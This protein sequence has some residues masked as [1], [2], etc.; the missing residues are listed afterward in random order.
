VAFLAPVA[1]FL[2]APVPPQRLKLLLLS[3]S[4]FCMAV[5]GLDLGL[6]PLMSRRL[7]YTPLNVYAHKLPQLPIVGRWDPDLHLVDRL[8]GDLAAVL[9]KAAF[10]EYREVA[11]LTDRAGFRNQAIPERADVI[12]LGDSFAA[13]W[14]TT[15]DKI[16]ARLLETRYGRRVY[17]LAY[18]GGPYDQF[19]NLCIESPRMRLTPDAKVVWTFYTGND[20]DDA[21]GETWDVEK[22][23]WRGKLGQWQV[24]YRTYRNRSPLNRLMEA[25]RWRLS[26]KHL[27]VIV[28][29][30]SDGR[31]V[32]FQGGHEAWARRSRDE[33]EQHPNFARLERTLAAMRRRIENPRLALTI[34]ILPTKGQVYSWLL[35]QDV[36]SVP[37]EPSSGFAQAVLGACERTG[38][39]CLDTTP[40][41]TERAGQVFA[42]TGELLWWR[43]DTHLGEQGHEALAEF[44][45]DR[46][47]EPRSP[48]AVA[49]RE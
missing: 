14:G 27:D 40:Y 45:A 6:R 10:R 49:L 18:P 3:L 39:R 19:V 34:L 37:S 35:G 32:L 4:V 11:F 48:S 9:G 20:L 30:L 16:F 42:S 23:P 5:S 36:R 33:V 44:I 47:L 13:G 22:L 28:R 41:L 15:Q 43:D 17:N 38:L 46:V 21:G 31:P 8:Y 29:Q 7:D 26:K 2:A 24:R 1:W 25:V 12:V